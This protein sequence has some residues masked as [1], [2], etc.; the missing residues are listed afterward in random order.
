VAAARQWADRYRLAAVADRL[1]D[2][3]E[4]RA[5]RSPETP[6]STAPD[7]AT[8]TDSEVAR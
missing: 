8:D 5:G 6:T 7:T 4:Q 1:G 2:L 3:L